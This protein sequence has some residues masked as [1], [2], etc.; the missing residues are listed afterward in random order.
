[1]CPTFRQKMVLAHSQQI[2]MPQSVSVVSMGP[3]PGDH[4]LPWTKQHLSFTVL[5][6]RETL[7]K[8]TSAFLK[9]YHRQGC[10]LPGYQQLRAECRLSNFY[11][12]FGVDRSL[13][14]G[15]MLFFQTPA[16]SLFEVGNC[17]LRLSASDSPPRFQVML[18]AIILCSRV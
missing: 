15:F 8:T 6:R 11:H 13:F 14:E 4:L 2:K 7:C 17:F 5:C 10:S 1:M 9:D 16:F 12:C 18:G 3:S